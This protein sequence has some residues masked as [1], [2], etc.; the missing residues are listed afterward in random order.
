MR[1]RSHLYPTLSRWCVKIVKAACRL[2]E[3]VCPKLVAMADSERPP[4]SFIPISDPRL[5][6]LLC[7]H[8]YVLLL[9]VFAILD[10]KPSARVEW[11]VDLIVLSKPKH[12]LL[13]LASA[14]PLVPKICPDTKCLPS[15]RSAKFKWLRVPVL[16]SIGRL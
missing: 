14:L 9:R 2:N 10:A 12:R 6:Y 16:V 1:S 13:I 15:R 7:P 11:W 4:L 5:Y 3:L 8:H